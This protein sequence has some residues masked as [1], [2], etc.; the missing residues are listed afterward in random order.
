MLLEYGNMDLGEYFNQKLPPMLPTE[1]ESFWRSIFAL[2]N[3]IKGIHDLEIC[4][5]GQKKEYS[6]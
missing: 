6:G 1:I 2:A 4:V 3:A 5:A